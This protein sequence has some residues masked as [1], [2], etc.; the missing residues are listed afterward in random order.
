MCHLLCVPATSQRYLAL[1]FFRCLREFCKLKGSAAGEV[2]PWLFGYKVLKNVFFFQKI[3][4]QLVFNRSYLGIFF[5]MK[6][7]KNSCP[8]IFKGFK[9][10]WYYEP[11][12]WLVH[13]K[14]ARFAMMSGEGRTRLVDSAAETFLIWGISSN[15]CRLLYVVVRVFSKNFILTLPKTSLEGWRKVAN[16]QYSSSISG[17]QNAAVSTFRVWSEKSSESDSNVFEQLSDG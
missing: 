6:L 2:G 5:K 4:S 16:S 13:H 8:F 7:W 11:P 12:G 14:I 3:D 15:L 9:F 1:H 17:S 10:S